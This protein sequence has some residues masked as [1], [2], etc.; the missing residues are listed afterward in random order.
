M[1]RLGRLCFFGGCCEVVGVVRM[2]RVVSF[3]CYHAHPTNTHL[4]T[5]T[6]HTHNT[7]PP[8]QTLKYTHNTPHDTHTLHNTLHTTHNAFY[9]HN[10]HPLTHTIH[11]PHVPIWYPGS[12]V[13]AIPSNTAMERAIRLMYDGRENGISS[14]T[15]SKSALS[16]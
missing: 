16:A 15:A 9:T 4:N 2:V 8:A 5:K 3:G 13:S 1:G 12:P 11:T 14:V 6:I 10:I 7:C